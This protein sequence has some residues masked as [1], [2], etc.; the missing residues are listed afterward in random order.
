MT[1]DASAGGASENFLTRI[2]ESRKKDSFEEFLE[3]ILA[4]PKSYWPRASG[5]ALSANTG[6]RLLFFYDNASDYH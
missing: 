1:E 5:P 6:Y 2:E 4:R 3:F